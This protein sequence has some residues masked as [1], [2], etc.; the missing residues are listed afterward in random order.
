MTPERE[1]RAKYIKEAAIELGFTS[2]GISRACFL[3]DD[4]RRLEKWL[5]SGMHAGMKY[6]EKHFEKR[7]DPRRL[8][9]GARSVISVLLNYYPAKTQEDPSAPVLAKYA[10][11]TDYH[12][13]I[14]KK[15]KK[16]HNVIKEIAGNVA[17]R[18]FVDSAPVLDRAWAVRSG[19]GWRGKN[20]CL[21]AG[22][23]GS[24]FFAAELIVD[25]DLPADTHIQKEKCGD[26][27]LCIEACPTGA[28]AEPY[29]LDARKCIS[30]ITTQHKGRIPDNFR[31]KMQNRVFGC[32]I[33]QDVCP[34]NQK[35]KSHSEP[36][37]DPNPEMLMLTSREWH[38]M[39]ED[40]FNSI[41]GNTVLSV[42]GYPM[43]KRNLEFSKG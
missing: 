25:M 11:G 14:K 5:S 4:A 15:L 19:L 40:R 18:S 31:D 42:S 13:V 9:P 33:C 28:L 20:N 21:I 12:Y 7:A 27:R 41:F 39:D 17:C 3:E 35:A 43:V 29:V 1:S 10:Y 2:C 22:N 23:E 8:F 24:F 34:F 36:L 26:C 6:M 30:Y 37:L 16:L 38:A 32:D